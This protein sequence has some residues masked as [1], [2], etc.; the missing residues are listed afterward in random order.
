[1]NEKIVGYILLVLGML[2]IAAS[3]ISVLTVFTARAK[4]VKIF[5]FPSISL[6]TNEIIAANL[7]REMSGFLN[8]QPT[9][10]QKTELISSD[11]INQTSSV[12][13]HLFLMGFL[14]TVGYKIASLGTQLIRPIVVNLKSKEEPKE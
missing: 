14:V 4:P 3:S 13:A 7:P 8:Q 11:M 5:N 10:V 12:F 2:I 9:Q 1:M 6:N